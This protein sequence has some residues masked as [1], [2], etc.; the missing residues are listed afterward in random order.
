MG[1]VAIGV[2]YDGTAYHGW[3]RQPHSCSVQQALQQALSRIADAPVELTC[4]GRTDAGV[5]ARAQVAHF[6]TEAQRSER[7][8]QFGVN[9]VLPSSINVRWVHPVTE[10]FHARFS[11]CAAPTAIWC[12]TGPRDRRWPQA[13]PWSSIRRFRPTSCRR[14]RIP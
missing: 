8:W 11:A 9:S 12:S 3:Q 2:E 6:D 5:H 7:A 14:R 10:Q 1:R 13:A 4:A